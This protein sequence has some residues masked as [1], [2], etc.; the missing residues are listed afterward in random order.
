MA[1]K[2]MIDPGIWSSEDFGS[3]S[4]LAKVVFVGLVS[5]ADDEGRGLANPQYLKSIL[6]PYDDKLRAADI[7]KTLSEIASRMSTTFYACDEKQYYVMENWEKYQSIN[8]PTTSKIPLPDDYRS[9]TVGLPPNRIEENRK[10]KKRA[11]EDAPPSKN[12]FVP[13]TEEEVGAY[14]AE[15][16]NSV[17]P[18]SF[19][20]FYESKGWMVGKSKMKD[21]RAA[22]R[23]WE[24]RTPSEPHADITQVEKGVWQL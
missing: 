9:T 22:V 3:L 15:R 1:R 11:R 20:N 6:F 8:K 16:D 18:K 23:T 24:Q 14:C 2:R 12:N 7:G 10:E 17:N 21:W 13:P 4:T 5:Q 19:V